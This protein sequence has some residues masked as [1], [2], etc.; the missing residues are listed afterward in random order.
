MVSPIRPRVAG[1]WSLGAQ[2]NVPCT[3][4]PAA[5]VEFLAQL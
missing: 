2:T 3:D 4:S 1:Q 5:L